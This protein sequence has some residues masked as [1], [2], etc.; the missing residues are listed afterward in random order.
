[1]R[2]RGCGIAFVLF[3]AA[4]AAAVSPDNQAQAQ[5]GYPNKP[6]RIIVGY[7]AGGGTDVVARVIG[8]K[9]AERLGQPVVVENKPGGGARI[10]V[11][12]VATQPADGYTI[13]IGGG[14]ELSI[15]P[16]IYK[17][18]YSP[19]TSFVPLTIAI[20]MPLILVAPPDHPAK[21]A[22]ELAAWAKANPGKSNYA[23]TA[24]G[25]TLPA[26]LFKLQ[27]GAPGVAIYYKSAAEG[28]IALMNGAASWATFTPPGIVN[29]VKDGKLRALAVTTAARSPDLPDT[30]SMKEL[31]LDINIANWNGFFL[32][33]GTP[34]PIAERLTSEMREI[35]LNTEVKDKLRGMFT[36]P[37][38]KTPAATTRHIEAEMKVWKGVIE[39]AQL[40]FSN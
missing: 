36:V 16:L 18:N 15:S 39:K 2:R 33:A 23:T 29:L 6:V 1:M 28:A 10:A 17:T 37:V 7:A 32:P 19:L 31:G 4:V 30:P 12:Y 8:E 21:T 14:S 5:G 34:R 22:T 40:K 26:E 20:E 35:V 25:F 27:T 9:L 3:L 24:P 38:G 13:L 11:D